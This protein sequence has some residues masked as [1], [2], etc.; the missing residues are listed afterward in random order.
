MGPES[1]MVAI[2]LSTG[3]L[4]KQEGQNVLLGLLILL[5]VGRTALVPKVAQILSRY[6]QIGKTDYLRLSL[7]IDSFS[8]TLKVRYI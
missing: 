4:G 7:D 3:N 5:D 2:S 6:L 8:Y 1:G